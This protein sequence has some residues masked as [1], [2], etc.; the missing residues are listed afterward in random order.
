[1]SAEPTPFHVVDFSLLIT[2]AIAEQDFKEAT[3]YND[4]HHC[5]CCGGAECANATELGQMIR[6]KPKYFELQEYGAAITG[7]CI[8]I[9][10]TFIPPFCIRGNIMGC[11]YL[12][13][14]NS[15]HHRAR[16]YYNFCAYHS[17]L[18]DISDKYYR[19]AWSI[20]LAT[21]ATASY[22]KMQKQANLANILGL[23]QINDQ[24]NAVAA[25]N[26]QQFAPPPAA[27]PPAYDVL[28]NQ[29]ADNYLNRPE[30][31]N[32]MNQKLIN[33]EGKNYGAADVG[34]IVDKID[35][36]LYVVDD[37]KPQQLKEDTIK[38][39]TSVNEST[40]QAIIATLSRR[41]TRKVKELQSD[42][43]STEAKVNCLNILSETD[44][45]KTRNFCST[46]FQRAEYSLLIDAIQDDASMKLSLPDEVAVLIMK[47]SV[48]GYQA[49]EEDVTDFLKGKVMKLKP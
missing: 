29:N 47:A 37:N 39:T 41:L 25:L 34:M 16:A 18:N 10:F 45:E 28:A 22:Q 23:A 5:R 46:V 6:N 35:P 40:R 2:P 30:H 15:Q 44:A 4:D 9:C 12:C 27:L 48:D 14:C 38:G 33:N 13:G 7:C 11:C 42:T 49:I 32:E 1:M 3:L 19:H 17:I 26:F 36:P 24:G 8:P 21:V 43:T 20:A 31:Q